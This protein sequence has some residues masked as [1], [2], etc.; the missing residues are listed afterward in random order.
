MNHTDKRLV[1]Q[2]IYIYWYSNCYFNVKLD[3]IVEI[4]LLQE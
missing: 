1:F 4:S 2:I 3:L